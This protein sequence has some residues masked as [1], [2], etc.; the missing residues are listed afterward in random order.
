MNKHP[1]MN[2]TTIEATE[3]VIDRHEGQTAACGERR[4]AGPGCWAA[5]ELY[6]AAASASAPDGGA[7]DKCEVTITFAD[8][9][10]FRGRY[11]LRRERF[12]TLAAQIGQAWSFYARRGVTERQEAVLAALR[13][14]SAAWAARCDT[15]RIAA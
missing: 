3:I 9:F 11:E 1:A 4:F 6:L 8:G 15:Y 12:S 14:D 5:A 13:V 2:T 7:C 10:T